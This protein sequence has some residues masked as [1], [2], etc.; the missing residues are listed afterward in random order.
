MGNPEEEL[1]GGSFRP[2]VSATGHGGSEDGGDGG[3]CL[4][5]DG[6][7]DCCCRYSGGGGG[8]DGHA[9]H[10][11]VSLEDWRETQQEKLKKRQKEP[12]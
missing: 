12:C 5:G 8:S 1:G 7:G 9:G 3:G 11:G 6:G 10:A 4:G 2:D